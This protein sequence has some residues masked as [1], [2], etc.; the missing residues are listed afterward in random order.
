MPKFSVTRK[1]PYSVE[2]V[3]AVAADVAQYRHFMPLVKRS[4]VRG[5][6]KNA[7]GG[8]TFD[9][10]LEVAY[11]KLGIKETMHSKVTV[12]P[13]KKLV[14][15]MSNEPPVSHLDAQWQITEAG[16]GACE[17]AFN[18]DYALKSRAM[19]FVLSGMFDMVV[20]KVMNAFEERA[21]ELYG[22]GKASV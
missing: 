13:V 9:A 7:D 6:L 14:R 2:Q 4:S 5:I 8:E 20:R 19:Q 12:D 18:V 11:K 3:F 22:P 10:E 15:A 21:R 1:V 17:I 16:A